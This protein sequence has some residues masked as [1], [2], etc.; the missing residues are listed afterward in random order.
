[1]IDASVSVALVPIGLGLHGQT[2][3]TPGVLHE[4]TQAMTN[5]IPA[6]RILLMC[7]GFA[8][9]LAGC[10]SDKESHTSP[11]SGD[12]CISDRISDDEDGVGWTKVVWDLSGEDPVRD[13]KCLSGRRG[14][15]VYYE[16]GPMDSDSCLVDGERGQVVGVWDLRESADIGDLA[17]RCVPRVSMPW[18]GYVVIVGMIVGVAF[19]FSEF[20]F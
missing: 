10:G 16:T 12:A 6:C 14:D 20:G 11:K 13:I 8:A 18:W 19:A 7:L 3:G 15:S 9:V 4:H 17:A 5:K 1:M 2:S